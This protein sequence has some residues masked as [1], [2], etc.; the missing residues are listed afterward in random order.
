MSQVK[1]NFDVFKWSTPQLLGISYCIMIDFHVPQFLN[2]R[3][4]S[5]LLKFLADV[6]RNYLKNPYHSFLHAVDVLE[7][8]YYLLT[9]L[10]VS[11][12][13]QNSD[14]MVCLI[15]SLC[16][17]MGH[18]GLNNAFQTS[19]KTDLAAKYCNISILENHSVDLTLSLLRSHNILPPA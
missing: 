9:D 12:Y 14:V 19:A 17:D 3:S 10:D 18:P 6:E 16:H 8:L 11:K 5:S 2:I 1:W 4:S 15:S 7:F 13:L